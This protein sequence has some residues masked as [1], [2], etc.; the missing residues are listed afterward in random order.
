MLTLHVPNTDPVSTAWGLPPSKTNQPETG[1]TTQRAREYVLPL[2]SWVWSLP[3]HE[4]APPGNKP[5]AGSEYS[6]VCPKISTEKQS[7]LAMSRQ[8]PSNMNYE[9]HLDAKS[10]MRQDWTWGCWERQLRMTPR[11]RESSVSSVSSVHG[12]H[13]EV[14]FDPWYFMFIWEHPVV[15]QR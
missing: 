15:N 2:G 7:S 11:I 10:S 8:W 9:N 13:T 3:P 12:L 14:T 5:G 1:D 6:L 4:M